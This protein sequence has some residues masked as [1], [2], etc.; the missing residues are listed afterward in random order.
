MTEESGR[1]AAPG[2]EGDAPDGD[3]AVREPGD[4]GAER[5]RLQA[6]AEEQRQQCLRLAAELDNLRKRS[7]REQ[8]NARQFA[9]ERFAGEL[10]GVVDS[11]EMGVAA[12]AGASAQALLEGSEATLRL[13]RATLEKHGVE[14]VDPEG[15]PFDPQLHEAM[16]TQP[17]QTVEPDSVLEVVQKG[18][19]LN[20]RLLRPARVIV[21][22]QP[23]PQN[24]DA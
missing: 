7:A 16:A 20:G 5:E 9:I 21:A 1:S 13:L 3:S 10:L 15:E 12:G 24:A 17:S 4:A 19:T 18:Y 11:L 23:A 14:V 8:A 2:A 6:E 22:A